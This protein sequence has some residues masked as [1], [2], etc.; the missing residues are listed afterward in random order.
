M[1][2]VVTTEETN[3]LPIPVE[4]QFNNAYINEKFHQRNAGT[5]NRLIIDGKIRVLNKHER[6]G[7]EIHMP[8][9]EAL[10]DWKA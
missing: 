1:L 2:D 9:N 10:E 8:S 6:K 3:P 4:K 5:K 7:I